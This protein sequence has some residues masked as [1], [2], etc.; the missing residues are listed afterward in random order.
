VRHRG[1]GIELHSQSPVDV[2][3]WAG[4]LQSLSPSSVLYAGPGEACLVGELGRRGI[5][6]VGVELGDE[7]GDGDGDDDVGVT[8]APRPGPARRRLDALV[9]LQLDRRFDLIAFDANSLDDASI[10]DRRGVIHAIA[11]HLL[12][13]GVLVTCLA[14]VDGQQALTLDQFEALCADCELHRVERWA[15]W[16]CRTTYDGGPFALSVH[17]RTERFN[18]HDLVFEARAR[19]TRVEPHELLA[20][21]G[22]ANPPLVVDTR[23]PS[24]RM[25]FGV[26]D[27]SVHV[28]RTVVEWRFD[29]ANGYRHTAFRS[30][31]QPIVVVCNGGYSSSLSAANLVRIGFT[32]VADLVGGINAWRAARLPLVAPSH[33][34]LDF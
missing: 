9:Q 16:S 15:D 29:P 11:Q 26:I 31:D 20:R 10:V 25:R 27:G 23:T 32:D 7:G 5:D 8:N 3:P 6:V 13:A 4:V 33:S 1:P 17:R 14:L 2:A 21:L 19:I 30:F 34:H 24:D 22:G 12:P 28:P 18:V